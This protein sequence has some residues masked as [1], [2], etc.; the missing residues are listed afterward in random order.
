[1]FML[2][3]GLISTLLVINIVRNMSNLSAGEWCEKIKQL[4]NPTFTNPSEVEVLEKDICIGLVLIQH[5]NY[6]EM[7]L[8]FKTG[9]S[10][11]M[12][13]LF[14]HTD[15]SLHFVIVTDRQS[16][17]GVGDLLANIVTRMLGTQA[18]LSR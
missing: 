1:M 14:K 12:D 9:V 5:K 2:L 15:S 11:M 8:S 7:E 13:S 10:K 6:T 4:K 18:V 3:V 17:Y 16:L